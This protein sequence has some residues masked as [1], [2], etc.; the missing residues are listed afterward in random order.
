VNELEEKMNDESNAQW[1]MTWLRCLT[2]TQLQR[3]ASLYTP[4]LTSPYTTIE[5]F[6]S[7]EVDSLNKEVDALQCLALATEM[8]IAIEIQ[9]L[10][11]SDG[12][13]QGYVIPEGQDKWISLLY[14][15]GHYDILYPNNSRSSTS[16]SSSNKEQPPPSS[17]S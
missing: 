11:G 7:S 16:T 3:H 13:M 6:C 8:Q 2:S 15:P 17:S 4:Y 1:Y 9:Y 14:R 12:A 5:A 10:D